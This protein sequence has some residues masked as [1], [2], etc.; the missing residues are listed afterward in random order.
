[1]ND[2]WSIYASK[3]K[4]LLSLFC[5]SKKGGKLDDGCQEV[6]TQ[7]WKYCWL[8]YQG[9]TAQKF[10]LIK[11]VSWLS[12]TS[13]KVLNDFFADTVWDF[14]SDSGESEDL[15]DVEETDNENR[16]KNLKVMDGWLKIRS[17]KPMW[18]WPWNYL[19]SSPW[20]RPWHQTMNRK[21]LNELYWTIS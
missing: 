5:C 6:P 13:E 15:S 1:M 8:L 11:M 20:S 9:F 12:Y 16:Q 2:L 14:N 4:T 10:S 17:R 18:T 19:C 3:N 21:V 7:Q